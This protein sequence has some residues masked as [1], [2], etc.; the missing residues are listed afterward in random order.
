[1]QVSTQGGSL[2]DAISQGVQLRK[3]EMPKKEM[4]GRGGLLDQIRDAG[5]IKKLKAVEVRKP[6]PKAAAATDE[7]D[8]AAVLSNKF[9]AAMGDDNDDDGDDSDDEEWD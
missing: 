3:A 9:K 7:F 1:M 5:N 6:E 2:T 4:T 8:V